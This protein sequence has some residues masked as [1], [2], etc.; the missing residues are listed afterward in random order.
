MVDFIDSRNIRLLAIS[1]TQ[2]T[3]IFL[4]FSCK[5]KANLTFNKYKGY[6]IKS[7]NAILLSFICLDFYKSN[8]ITAA[9]N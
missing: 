9:K 3:I 2:T 1:S 6:Y 7:G 8:W 4:N 5:R